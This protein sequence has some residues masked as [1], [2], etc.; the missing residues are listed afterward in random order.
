MKKVLEEEM[1]AKSNYVI[2]VGIRV[3]ETSTTKSTFYPDVLEIS[4]KTD[5][6]EIQSTAEGIQEAMGWNAP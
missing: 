1:E 4:E 5:S 3:G 6:E 2:T